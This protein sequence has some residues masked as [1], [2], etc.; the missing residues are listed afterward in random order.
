MEKHER[1]TQKCLAIEDNKASLDCLKKVV[2][3]SSKSNSCRPKLVLLV[4]D[5][6]I[7]CKKAAAQHADAI[8]NGTIEKINV[9]SPDGKA[10]TKINN[11][12]FAPSLILLDCNNKIINPV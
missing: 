5:G 3:A 6:C 11:I 2:A 12:D 4:Q 8:A 9:H 10:I 7:P 1:D